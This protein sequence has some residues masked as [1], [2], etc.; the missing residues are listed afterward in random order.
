MAISVFTHR[1]ECIPPSTN[2]SLYYNG[3]NMNNT[4]QG[5]LGVYFTDD[6]TLGLGDIIT[7]PTQC[8]QGIDIVFL[9]DYTASMGNAIEGVKTGISN[10]LSTISTES[11]NNS[12]VGLV[13]FDE[14]LGTS[15]NSTYS[16]K[17]TYVNLPAGQKIVNVNASANRTQWITAIS[18]MGAV[19]DFTDFNAK[20]ALLN[21]TNFLM[22]N[23]YGLP[24]PGDMGTYEI[25]KNNLAGAWREEAIKVVILIT[26]DKPGGDD[27]TNNATDLAYATDI[28]IPALNNKGVQMIVQSNMASSTSG[29]YYYNL[30]T[31]TTIPGRYDQVAFD[32]NGNWVNTGLVTGIQALCDETYYAT[33]D[34]ASSGWYY[35]SGD[36]YSFYFDANTG[37]ITNINYFAPTYSV[38][39]STTSVTENGQ[40]II[41]TITTNYVSNGTILYWDFNSGSSVTSSDFINA[42]SNGSF[43]INNGIG[44]F[45]L[46]TRSDSSTEGTELISV[47]IRTGSVNGP[48]VTASD[49]TLISDTSQNVP[50]STPVPISNYQHYSAQSDGSGNTTSES[51][52]DSHLAL[53]VSFWS[54]RGSVLGLQ[55]GDFIYSNSAGTALWNGNG[56]WYQVGDSDYL[57]KVIKIGEGQVLSITNCPVEQPTPTA[58]PMPTAAPPVINNFRGVGVSYNEIETL[59]DSVTGAT[60]TLTITWGINGS[61]TNVGSGS[62]NIFNDGSFN[63]ESLSPNTYYYIRMTAANADSSTSEIRMVKTEAIIVPTPTPTA[64]GSGSGSGSGTGTSTCR[65]VWVKS[66]V[67][68]SRYGLQWRNFGNTATK[69]F[70][71]MLGVSM[72]YGGVEGVVYSVCSTL[73]PGVWDF[74]STALVVLS[75]DEVVN[76]ADGGVCTYDSD[77]VYIT[78]T[79]TPAPTAT[80]TPTPTALSVYKYLMDPCDGSSRYVVAQSNTPKSI[81]TVYSLSGSE[82]AD[83]NYTCI[84]N[85][86][87]FPETTILGAATCDFDDP[88]CLL[89]GTL[90]TL[91]DGTQKAIET[92]AIGDVLKSIVVGDMPNSDNTEVLTLW[93]QANPTISNT[94]TTVQNNKMST[95]DSVLSFNNGRLTSSKDHL[96]VIK[97]SGNWMVVIA[98][99]VVVGDIFV[100]QSGS[101]ITITSIEELTGTFNV[102]KLDVETNDTYIAS[103]IITHNAKLMP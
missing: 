24:E 58:T 86:T 56:Y 91:A 7:A 101:E 20:L 2:V 77:C 55:V 22:G 37:E 76:F 43:T 102:Y 75:G 10:I 81:G 5:D 31:Q 17:P 28:L 66:T 85:S 47:R 13:L 67:D 69:R 62:T 46:T 96:H 29:N 21:T 18:K 36:W 80:A 19:N 57:Q 54:E 92:I 88:E 50:T 100:T 8:T 26:D 9:V 45:Q 65:N 95:V 73:V 94:T 35:R 70:N 33:C 89:A 72:W 68:Q 38:S 6:A 39:P 82:Y 14:Y 63:L 27:D 52:C 4:T 16:D 103:D 34:L 23:G 42:I 3:A 78:P 25:V 71:Q 64:A 74:N 59:W 99:S 41:W 11:L 30:T 48:V 49:F 79:A 32:S 15:S 87:D 61:Y 1:N 90:I 93:S 40:T 51:S 60:G 84:Q 83:Q 97:R 44:S 53:Y 98:S 12:R